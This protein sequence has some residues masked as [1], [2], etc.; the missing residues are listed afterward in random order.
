[1]TGCAML[2]RETE[3]NFIVYPSWAELEARWG[4]LPRYFADPLHSGF[5]QPGFDYRRFGYPETI[6]PYELIDG[7]A[8]GGI[9]V[10]RGDPYRGRWLPLCVVTHDADLLEPN[11]VSGLSTDLDPTL[12]GSVSSNPRRILSRGWE[13]GNERATTT[14][15]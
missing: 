14:P 7:P 1:M 9:I 12:P 5:L 13:S 11:G 15:P 4:D 6:Q 3:R 2:T 8:G 10:W